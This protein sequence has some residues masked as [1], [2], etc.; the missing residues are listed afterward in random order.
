MNPIRIAQFG[1]GP[2]G[3]VVTRYLLERGGFEIV[4]AV[5]LAPALQGVDL[6]QVAGLPKPLGLPI[7][8]DVG[9]A[10]ATS[11][12]EVAIVTTTSS[13]VRAQPLLMRIAQAGL[14][15][16]STCEELAYPWVTQ[17][18]IARDLDAAA[19]Q[20]GVAILS[21]GVNPGFLMDTLPLVLTGV[22]QDV[23]AV[24]V[25]RIQDA[26]PRRVPFQIKIGAG[27]T[28]AQFEAKVA[29]GGVRHVGLTESMHMIAGALGWTLARTEDRIAP[30]IADEP[31]QVGEIAI[32][33]GGVRGVS[34]LGLGYVGSETPITL[35]F[36]AA[37]GEPT[38]YE[39]IVIEGTPG[40]DMTL[41]GG[42]NG[43]V[44]TGAIVVNAARAI[45]GARPGLRTMA[46]MP[47][48]C[49]RQ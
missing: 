16:V 17:P 9:A 45:S 1:L 10:L 3:A 15:I 39:R 40:I 7:S 20:A 38:S 8:D 5:D 32:E 43:D 42:V 11:G 27:L 47:V 26:R 37:I 12:A 49:W 24:R 41:A 33:A 48:V 28:V 46:D 29:A 13:L 25:E 30:V 44:A 2:I 18:D 22:C 34:Q 36:R 35:V 23:R 21:T 19:R 14:H 4:A 6:G 31:M